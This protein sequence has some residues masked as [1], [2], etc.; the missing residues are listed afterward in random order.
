MQPPSGAMERGPVSGPV[1][2]SAALSLIEQAGVRLQSVP[3]SHLEFV[4]GHECPDPR[5]PWKE[6][7]VG[8]IIPV[9]QV[10]PAA[11]QEAK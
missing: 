5:A 7:G 6:G 10:R 2:L 3:S 11:P 1:L 9:F 4:P 8:C